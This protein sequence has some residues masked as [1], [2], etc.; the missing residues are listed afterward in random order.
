MTPKF[1]K[2]EKLRSVINFEKVI[3]G[4]IDAS[5][6]NVGEETE[7]TSICYWND[8]K[9]GASSRSGH[10]EGYLTNLDCTKSLLK[11]KELIT[12]NKFSFGIFNENTEENKL[13]EESLKNEVKWKLIEHLDKCIKNIID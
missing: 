1:K 7:T 3:V 13:V 10:N 6:R 12:Q 2:G 8:L 9:K 4:E 11:A 5:S